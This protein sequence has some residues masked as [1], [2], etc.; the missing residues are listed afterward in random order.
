SNSARVVVLRLSAGGQL[1]ILSDARVSLQLARQ[2]DSK[3]RLDNG[4]VTAAIDAVRDFQAVARAAGAR[5]VIAVATAAIRSAS[6]GDQVVE[7]IRVATG[8]SVTMIDGD[9]EA[10][11]PPPGA[12]RV[13][14]GR[15]GFRRGAGR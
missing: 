7:R 2:L 6:N 3:G 5:R 10:R 4:A 8:L 12:A 9:A 13:P 11:L 14:P 1:E 15:D